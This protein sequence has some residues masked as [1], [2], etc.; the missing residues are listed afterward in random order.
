MRFALLLLA[1]IL[2]AG[3]C[4]NPPRDEPMM[5][6][7]EMMD[8]ESTRGDEPRQVALDEPFAIEAGET[9]RL[10]EDGATIRFDEVSSDNRCPANVNCVQAGE[11]TARF[12]LLETERD[13]IPFTLKIN[14]G[15]MEVQDMERYQFERADR[16][17]AALLLL[18][19][20]PG[21]DGEGDMPMTAT[22]EMR[23]LM[24]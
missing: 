20:Y 14:G 24:R 23:R 15:V 10:A 22:L 1:L 11:A 5:D 4:S 9:V 7:D 18:Q 13:D 12:T 2:T 3:A 17:V 8:D 6:A 16:F 19:P 21:L